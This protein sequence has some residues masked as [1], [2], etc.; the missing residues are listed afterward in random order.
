MKNAKIITPLVKW[1]TMPW[2]E[3]STFLSHSAMEEELWLNGENEWKREGCGW[4]ERKKG[5]K[6]STGSITICNR[7]VF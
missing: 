2:L 4:L 7:G 3:G 5:L 1:A 6:A